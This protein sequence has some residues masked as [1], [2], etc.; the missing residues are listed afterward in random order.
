MTFHNTDT[1]TEATSNMNFYLK[2]G[3]FTKCDNNKK[4]KLFL[5]IN[6]KNDNVVVK[7]C[8]ES[9]FQEGLSGE[10]GEGLKNLSCWQRLSESVV[11]K[12]AAVC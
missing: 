11:E 5:K 6:S 4:C 7:N 10:M 9:S 12:I 3:K 1:G 2:N 8:G